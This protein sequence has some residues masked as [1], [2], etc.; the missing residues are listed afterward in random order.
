MKHGGSRYDRLSRGLRRDR[1]VMN[2][3]EQRY[4]DWLTNDP[5]VYRWWFEALSLRISHPEAGRPAL[6]TPDFVVLRED[7]TTFIDDVKNKHIDDVAA[8]V[9]IKA[10]A[11]LYPLWIFRIVR[12][13]A[14]KNGGGFEI[15]EV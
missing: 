11:E 12:P 1:G 4:A 6:Y 5:S 13:I 3:T 8:I 9:R 14:K 7:G 10:C 2:T 15:T